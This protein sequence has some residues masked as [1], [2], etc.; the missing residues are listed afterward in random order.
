VLV[1][2]LKRIGKAT[3]VAVVLTHHTSQE[4]AQR[5]PTLDLSESAF[6]GGTALVNNARQTLLAVNLGSAFDPFPDADSRTV[7]RDLVARGERERITLVACL[8]SSKS[9]EPAPLFFRW[10]DVDPYGPRAVEVEIK[11]EV[12][13]KSWRGVHKMLAGAKAEASADRKAEKE[14]AN[15]RVAIRAVCDL[16]EDGQ[17]PTV[18]KVSAKCGR[19]PNWAKPYLAAAVELGDLVRTTEQVPRVRGMTD[20]YRPPSTD[21]MGDSMAP[22]MK[23]RS[24][25]K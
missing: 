23:S 20:V 8:S 1:A 6:R 12:A 15:V 2:A 18:A 25:D 10:E 11:G 24:D 7:L 9:A 14:Q 4:S 21:S 16:A 5:L 3:G 22:W 17:I 13:G 19:N